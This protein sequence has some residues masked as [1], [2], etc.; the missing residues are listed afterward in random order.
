MKYDFETIIDRS[1][2]GSN[3]WA[4][5]LQLAPDREPDVLPMSTADMEFMTAPEIREG[6]KEYIDKTILGYTSATPAY[7]GAVLSWQHRHF[8]YEGKAEWIVTTSGVVEAIVRLVSIL[9]DPGDG[10]II[11]QPVY[12]PFALAPR[13]TGRKLV[14]N[15]L[16]QRENT[17]E[18]DF[19]DLERKAADPKNKVLIFCNPHNPVG[20]AWRREELERVVDICER[21]NV[22]IIDD[23]IHNDLIMPGYTHTALPT[24]SPVASKICAYCT[25]PSKTFNLAGMKLSNIFIENEVIRG[26]LALSKLMVMDLGQVAI[27]YEACRLAYEKGEAWLNELLHVVAD[28][29]QYMKEFLAAHIPEARCYPLEATYLQWVDFSALE[30]TS[31]ELHQLMLDAQLYLDDGPMFGPEG[32]GFQRFNLA[33]PRKAL[34]AGMERLDKAW[35]ALKARREAEGVPQRMVLSAGMTMPDFTY[36][37]P[38]ARNLSFKAQ[39]QGKPTLLVFHRYASCA[40]CSMALSELASVSPALKEQGMEVKVVLQS[41]PENVCAENY[42]F[43]VICDSQRALYERFSVFPAD[44]IYA[45]PGDHLHEILPQAAGMLLGAGQPTEGDSLQLPALFLIGADG[46]IRYAHYGEDLFD[47]PLKEALACC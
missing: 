36:D 30:L 12:Y 2:C 23:E 43:E 7:Y 37:T 8:G 1:Q 27:S 5:M 44:T 11:Q 42:P 45:L 6:M 3:K 22:F 41:A 34:A 10:V 29:A 18:I 13:I 25:A 24:I 47:L 15:P 16:I 28:N 20:K 4:E 46:V 39:T 33:L 40:F 26:K 19:E 38:A 31:K 17:Y 32:R 21:N 35:K 14:D 9:T